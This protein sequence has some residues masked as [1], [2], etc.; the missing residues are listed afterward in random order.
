MLR[1]LFHPRLLQSASTTTGHL[2]Q[3]IIRSKTGPSLLLAAGMASAAAT[4]APS[5]WKVEMYTPTA[6][7]WPYTPFDFARQ[8]EDPDTEFYSSPKYVTHIDDNAIEQ[9]AKYYDHVLPKFG[10]VLDFCSSWVSHYPARMGDGR[11]LYVY[12]MGLNQAELDR[13]QLFGPHGPPNR[14]VVQDLNKDPNVSHAF[15]DENVKFTAST[16]T[17]SID[18]L[19]KPLEV[20][21]SLREKTVEDGTVHLAI[22]NRA[23]WHKVVARWMEVGERERLE[24][25]ADYLWFAGWR[26]VEIVTVC[27]GKRPGVGSA[28][29]GIFAMLG[30][31]GGASD[32]LWVVR[33]K[34][35]AGVV[36]ETGV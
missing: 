17:V 4:K 18:Y 12:G 25:V 1:T 32:P 14:K 36:K 5:P 10:N 9:L 3:R 31:S 13:N 22:S 7:S 35:V 26:E 21:R 27:E 16:C 23:F 20:L 11:G 34:N 28:G 15:P 2:S 33:G 30:M 24:M 29:S 19:A 6:Q 8:D